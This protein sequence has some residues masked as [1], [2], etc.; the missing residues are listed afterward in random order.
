MVYISKINVRNFKSFSGS[1]KLNFDQGFNVI[2]GPN[3]SGKSNIIDAVQ[4]VFGELGSKRMRVPDLSGLIYDGA[5]QDGVKPQYSQVTI[6]F[7]NADR[8]LAIDRKTVSVGRRVD[9]A[10]K[11]KYFLNG[12]QTSRRRLLDILVLAGISP[13]G[14]NL[15]LQGTATRLSDLTPTER[16]SAL[17]DLVGI[18]EY[19]EKKFEAKSRLNEAERKI[20]VAS[21][22]GDEVRKRVGELERQRNDAIRA[23]L[24]TRVEQRYTAYKL[25]F[26]IKNLE[27][28]IH[29]IQSQIENNLQEIVKIDEEKTK[30]FD[31]REEARGRLEEYS[32]EA[33]EKGNTQLPLLTSDLVGRRTV[34][35]SL[36]QKL[37]E[38]D[39]KKARLQADVESKRTVIGHSNEEKEEKRQRL[40]ELKKS[41]RKMTAE[42]TR[43]E[44]KLEALT[45]NINNLKETAE[46]NQ[47]RVEELTESLIPMQESLSGLEIEINRHQVNTNSLESKLEELNR[48][49]NDSE[50]SIQNLKDK[51]TQLSNL[52]LEEVK[53]LEDMVES[54]DD[55][56]KRQKTLRG[57]IEGANKLAKNAEVTI[58][59]FNAKRD[60][61]KNV[62]TEE[63]AL[64]RIKEIGDAGALPGYHG[65]LRDLVKIDLKY[66][67]AANTAADGWIQGV[68]VDDLQTAIDCIVR[69]KKTKLGMTR[70][71]PIKDI[72]HPEALDE[73]NEV[74]VV[75]YLPNLLRYPEQY[76]PAIQLVWGDT[77]LAEDQD[78][79][80]RLSKR[81][82]RAVTLDGNLFEAAGGLIGGHWRRP[83]DY[84]KLIPSEESIT[85]LS[86]TIKTLRTRLTR[87]MT[88]LKKSGGNLREFTS[89]I[90]HFNNNIEG[91][92]GQVEDTWENIRR[93]ERN[94][95]TI[96]ENS[97][98][99]TE[100]Q[101][102]QLNLISTL[103]ERKERTLQE[104]VRIKDEIT[105]LKGLS[106]SDVASLEVTYNNV[107]REQADLRN[108]KSQIVSEIS[109]LTNLISQIL[110]LK[111]SDSKDQINAWKKEITAQELERAETEKRLEDK[112]QEIEE[113]Q[114]I[115]NGVTSEV[116]A[117]SR[118]LERH[119]ATLRR[120][121]AHIERKE[122]NRVNSERRNM[123]LNL[124][125]E[126]F[127]LQIEQR[128]EELN[129]IGFEFAI[130]VKDFDLSFVERT[131]QTIKREKYSLGMI[132]QLAIQH[133]EQ[134][135]YNYMQ[136]SV[137]INE[138]EKERGS[139]LAFIEEIELEKTEHFMKA[140]NQICENFTRFFE[141]LTGGGDG[142]LELQKPESPFSGGI[143]LY[144]QFPGKPMRLASGAS[145][146][147]RSVAAIAYLLAIQ[148][149]LKAPF[150]LFDEI[151]AHLDDLNTARLADVL[152]ENAL[153]SQ[154]LMVSLKDVMVHNADKI[155]GVF[156]Q[157]GRSK[158]LSLPMKVEVAV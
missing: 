102:R 32:R 74:G 89:Y 84:S 64:E 1:I 8:G 55:Q 158:V 75:G 119:R 45:G 60:L 13:G 30:L 78:T 145:G 128:V 67:R 97:L 11:S 88:D 58:T 70:F 140:Y 49:K 33:S 141:K 79:A 62:V 120:I 98:K 116:E 92:E 5:D 148:Q 117:S 134:D 107:V 14:Y 104:I 66:Q 106:P 59:Q 139:I 115:L 68:V 150:Y 38:I 129:R 118:I 41:E 137:R 40:K 27:E 44:A 50:N 16:M 81:G 47:V 39:L 4:F 43:K 153:E 96:D 77:Y 18:T 29:S 121:G 127:R 22:K 142:R 36:E 86:T 154:F 90:D 85:E 143:D 94:I 112:I 82:I 34:K 101:N 25:T 155:Y 91:I 6:Y 122:N 130:N 19:D 26:S 46:S 23:N 42:I 156:A 24:L 114:K 76:R 157:G 149:F 136:L 9:R 105:Q 56:V 113:L 35:N 71:L 100:E 147:E 10:G 65:P 126:K 72:L 99:I 37:R 21:A 7:N 51:I 123:S 73:I 146:G 103:K 93:L 151:D 61:W 111:T 95:T 135:A 57:T 144:V 48:K 132:N 17:E 133:Y 54:I 125:V 3:G 80:L 69:L 138:L 87:R 124:E 20:E 12:K 110:D 63:K 2:T 31:E 152:K 131:L 52:K 83:P 53:K 28:K 109:V 108:R 15:V